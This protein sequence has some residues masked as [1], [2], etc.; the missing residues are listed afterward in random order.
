MS[1]PVL[2]T[3]PH[4]SHPAHTHG[5]HE[6]DLDHGTIRTDVKPATAR[7]LTAAFV[8]LI[9]SVPLG[10][11]AWELAHRQHP[12]VL[13]LFETVPTRSSLRQYEEDLEDAAVP[14]RYVQP[15]IQS[16]V[17]GTLG[18]GS[19][20]VVIGCDGWLFYTP[21]VE[22]LTGPGFLG[23]EQIHT[24]HKK[25]V[26]EGKTEFRPDPRPAILQ[27]HEQCQ[28]RGVRLV[29]LPIPDKAQ[30]QPAQVS[31]S[32]R[33][34][35]PILVPN[36]PDY[37][38]FVLGLRDKGVEVL[39]ILPP[40]L[41]PNDRRFL[42]QDT[43]WT[44]QW[45]D[46][47]AKQVAEHLRPQ[48]PAATA[49]AMQK[50]AEEVTR[51]G[52]LVDMLRLPA[53]QKLFQPQSVSVERI[54][55][56]ENKLAWQSSTAADVLVLGDSFCN[57]F[58]SEQMG[59][60]GSAGFVEHL[61]YHLGRPL[62]RLVR[63]DAGAH[64]TREMLSK[65]LQR[66]SDR[67]AGKKVL[68]WEFAARELACGDWKLLPMTLGEKKEAEFYVPEAGRTVE[69]RGVVRAASPAPRPGTVPY[70]D[71]ILTIHLA[72][73]TSTDEPSAAGKEA[74]VFAWS[75][76]DNKAM[77]AA[78]LRPG[79]TV[80]LRLQPWTDVAAKYESINRS[81]LDDENL[82]F[83]DPAWADDAGRE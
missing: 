42:V 77:P 66:G 73:I 72:E 29:L 69:V 62:D 26:D 4:V 5:T 43:H 15:A 10:Q 24:R 19:G 58:S 63:N 47:V 36:N 53:D 14:R 48:L 38:R 46:E 55:A 8:L 20:K 39:D 7:V 76:R 35:E 21:G 32:A 1:A 37:E 50:Q 81:T 13:H 64:A 18:F 59:W 80:R 25:M 49:P 75:M 74:V 40:R 6:Y 56:A 65:E 54:V 45:M 67:L 34:S 17:S 16:A 28:Q 82:L 2:K 83:A 9:F 12:V 11:V 33:F 52:D 71:H 68:I 57:I 41:A 61:A 78:H 30:I 3:Q 22:Y 27:F 51:L 79:D 60:G 23:E 44:P 31:R 70:K